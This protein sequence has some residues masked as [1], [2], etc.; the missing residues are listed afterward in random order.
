MNYTYT[1]ALTVS[2]RRGVHQDRIVEALTQL[3][4]DD[5]ID[6]YTVISCAPGPAILKGYRY[7]LDGKLHPITLTDETADRMVEAEA[8]NIGTAS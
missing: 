6:S 3:A 4:R 5:V 2:D 7:G 1:V 8:S